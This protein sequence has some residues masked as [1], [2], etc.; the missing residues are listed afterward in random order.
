M[1]KTLLFLVLVVFTQVATLGQQSLLF[2][3]STATYASVANNAALNVAAGESATIITWV[4]TT[5][6]AGI[7]VFLAKR[8]NAAGPGYEF[9][10]LNGFL[11][12]NCTHTNGSSSGLPG[13]SKYRINDGKWHQL[14][15]VVDN[16][17]GN[18][19]MY[20]DGKL[21]VKKAMVST[22]GISNTDKLYVGIRG[23]LAMPTNGAIDEVRIYNKALTP[24][25]LLIDMAATVTAETP[26]LKAAWNFEEGAG[27][28]AADVK[29]VCTA[30]L[31]GAPV[32]ETLST[33]GAQVITMNGPITIAKGAPA[34]SPAT[35]TSPMP[36]QY[37]SSNPEVA[38]VTDGE[39]K[40][41]GQGTSTLTAT[42]QANL[43]YAAA[44]PVAQL[45]TVSKTVVTFGFPLSSNA[46]IQ[47]DKPVLITGTAEPGDVLTVILDGESKSVSVDASGNW[48]VEFAAKPAKNTAFTLSAEGANSQL[49]TLTNLLCGDVWV[50]SGQSNMLMPI[51]PG[52]SLGGITNYSS[53][54]AAA[55]YPAIRFIQPVDL[56]QQ[57]STPQSK[58]STSSNG[59]TVCS[60][61]T[62]AGYSAVAY[63]FA[64]QIHLDQNIPI[65]IIQNAIGGTRVEAWT[66]LAA[67]QSVPEYTSWYTKATTTSLPS[68]Q[69]Y[70]RKNFPAANFNGMLAPYTRNPVKGII[71][72]QGEENLGI[73]GIPA[74]NEYGAKMKATIQG[75]RAA[76]GISDL[77]VIFTELANYKYSAM[78]SVLGSS[79][80]ALPRFIAQ[81]QKATQLPG[82]YGITITDV[83]NYNDIHP[84]EKATVGIRMG[85]T[86]LG[87]VYGKDIVPTAATFKEMKSEGSA[88]RVSFNNA[89]GFRLS[90]G[91]SIT[92]FKIAGPDKVF[93]TAIAV[94]DGNDIL[95]SE[96]TIQQ[97]VAVK[98]AW[99]ENSNPNLING[100]NS[101]TARFAD[102]LK[103]N[104]ISFE[105]LPLLL[106]PGMPDLPLQATATSGAPVVFASSNSDVAEIVNGNQL[107]MK[108][109][110]TAVITASEP[111]STVY[112][113]ALP[114]Q[115]EISVIY[116][117]LA[118]IDAA[119]IHIQTI[120][121]RTFIVLKGLMSDTVVEVRS[122]DGKLV[123]SRKAGSETCK[124]E[125]E[126][127]FGVH[128]LTCT[129][130]H[131]QQQLK[132]IP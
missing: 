8:L 43:F 69:V 27:T 85:N 68:G 115:Q 9:F 5:Y 84:T 61:S 132:F 32:W 49:T 129:D 47:R 75:W 120:G 55:N 88:L 2:T 16:D 94:I 104:R 73:D 33:P 37:T 41:V 62:A 130:Q 97:P 56:W 99:D 126:N 30:S 7:Q 92:E 71:W 67:L 95:L 89:K 86:A 113:A 25:E 12:V 80:E 48:T 36:I 82:V 122:A 64:R 72:Y 101:P 58:L 51:G 19:Y 60:S 35:S 102:S 93:K 79:R 17:G 114:V 13:G 98:F 83:S 121:N 3:G 78:Y 127:L 42:Q 63:F 24:A 116:S 11:A 76:W 18:Y 40:V 34:F 4:K 112:A 20:V 50:A 15:F 28:Q 44:E 74:T 124:L 103:V 38:V 46:V 29:G 81:Q 65:G 100:S 57:A 14:A 96:A 107:R 45:L 123:M 77:P 1:K 53:V 125:F 26:G 6:S 111:G 70:D 90:T 128:I 131:K 23:N 31:A 87:Y 54:V 105:A 21:D 52:Y 119:N 39:I 108:S 10:Q 91:T 109:V 66:P 59:W 106:T 110:G 22:S 118:A 117:G